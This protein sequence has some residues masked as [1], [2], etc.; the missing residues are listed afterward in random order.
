M[1]AELSLV[2][3]A[4]GS[5]AMAQEPP[6]AVVEPS[7][8]GSAIF[9]THVTVID[10]ETGKEAQ[11][12][13]AVISGDR[14]SEVKESSEI[15]IA[16]GSKTVDGGGRYFIPSLWQMHSAAAPERSAETGVLKELA[17]EAGTLTRSATSRRSSA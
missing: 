9:I 11:N 13:T 5:V 12:R 3:L 2:V 15:K 10:T 17:C 7:R 6:A 14:I 8:A 16:A 4:L 1:R